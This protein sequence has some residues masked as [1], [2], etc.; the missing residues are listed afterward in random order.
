MFRLFGGNSYYMNLTIT[1]LENWNTESLKVMGYLFYKCNQL[2]TL[3]LSNWNT[4]KVTN[5]QNT[6]RGLTFSSLD[7]SN[8]N[9]SSVGNMRGMFEDYS[10]LTTLKLGPNWIMSQNPDI[11]NLFSNCSSLKQSGIDYNGAPADTQNKI[12][13]LVPAA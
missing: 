4:S 9:T 1:G 2:Q 7:L 3:D 5:M 11:G 13:G 12:N 6:F 8:W 10:Q